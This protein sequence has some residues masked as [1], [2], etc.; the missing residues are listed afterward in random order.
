M[1]DYV[2]KPERTRRR[3]RAVSAGEVASQAPPFEPAGR[4]LSFRVLGPVEVVDVRGPVSVGGPKERLVLAHLLAR[5]NTT[6]SVDALVEGVWAGEPPRSAE[7]TLQAYVARLRKALEPPRPQGDAPSLLVTVGRGY[8]LDLGPDQLDAIQF[9][10]LARRGADELRAGD[11]AAAGTL[12]RALGLWRGEPYGEFGGYEACAPEARRLAEIR[13]VALEDRLDADLA[14]GDAAQV[15][16]EAEGLLVDYSF[17]ERLWGQLMLALYRSGRQRDALAAYQRARAVLV[18]ELGIEPGPDLRRLEAA[19]LAQDPSLDVTRPG[20]GTEPGGLPLVLEAVGSA[21]VGRDTE[22]AWLREGWEEAAAGRGRFVSVLGPEGIG[23]T[24]LIT[25]LARQAHSEGAVVL[26]GRCDHAHPGARALLDQALRSAGGS[27]ARLDD[28]GSPVDDLAGAVARFLPTWSRGRPVLLLLDDLHLA[29]TGT[30]E[31]LADLAGWCSAAPMLVVGAFRADGDRG[32]GTGQ[33]ALGGLDDDA[34]GRICALYAEEGWATGDLARLRE[35]TGGVPLRVHEQA[36]EWARQRAARRVEETTDR[37]TAAR[38]RVATSRGELAE[39]VE[40]I[41]RLLEERRAQLAGREV[42]AAADQAGSV[43]GRCPYKGLARFETAD[44]SD[45]FGRER[46]VAEL[47]ARLAGAGLLAVVGPS[48]SGKSS[49]VR[50][51]LLPALADGVLPGTDRWQT[52][53]LCPGAHPAR[54]L[55]RQLRG[56]ADS[57]AA[58]R[59]LVFV[60]Q[61]EETF[62][63][64]DDETER[65]DFV[66]RLVELAERPT[67]VVVLAVRADHLGLCATYPELADLLTGNDVLVGPMRD[68]ELRR[69]VELPARR[70]GLDVEAGL[71]EVIVADVAGRAGALPL[72]S[73]AL[74]ETWE[75]RRDRTLTLA[76][77]RAA[78]GVNGA[79]ARLAEDAYQSMPAGARAAGRRVLLRLCDAG[80]DGTID[81]RRRLPMDEAAPAHDADARAA[82]DTLVDRRLLTVDRDSVEVAHEALLREWPRLRTWLDEDVQGRRLH[83]RLGDAARAWRTADRDPSELYRGT[84]LDSAVDWAAAHGADLN[85]VEQEFLDASRADAEREVEEVKRRSAEKTR[86]NRRL[87]GL[88]AGVAVLLVIALASGLL[89]LR[90]RDRAEREERVTRVR[91][92]SGESALALEEDPE[93]SI[94]LGLEA[95]GISRAAG[96]EPLPEAIGALQR[97]VQESR[98]ELRVDG[99]GYNV[100][101]SADGGLL[102]AGA[103]DG[104]AAVVLDA[105]TGERLRELS[106]PAGLLLD[107]LAFAPDG[108]VVTSFSRGEDADPAEGGPV[109]IMWDPETGEASTRLPGRGT[110]YPDTAFTRDGRLLAASGTQQV[111]VWDVPSGRELYTIE[112][113]PTGDVEFLP[114]DDTFI[115]ALG[116]ERIGFY[117]AADGHAVGELATPGFVPQST[118]LDPSGELLALA[119]QTSRALQ[120]WNLR[121]RDRIWSMALG[122]TAPLD[123]SPDGRQLAIGGGNL[124]P[125]QVLDVESGAITTLRGHEQVWDVA[126]VSQDRLASVDPFDGLRIWN[127]TRAGPPELGAVAASTGDAFGVQVSPDG[128]EVAITTVGGRFERVDLSTGE[129]LASISGQLAS[130]GSTP[131]ISPD[132]R[133]MASVSATDGRP[134]VRDLGTLEPIHD[135]PPCTSPRAFSPDGSLIVLNGRQPCPDL[136][137]PPP[138]VEL[139]SRVVEVD[140]GR[141]VLAFG[142]EVEF[143]NAAAFSSSGQYLAINNSHGA[144]EVYDMA[145]EPIEQ[146]AVL[147]ADDLGSPVIFGPGDRS[148]TVL[149]GGTPDGQVWVYDMAEATE[150]SSAEP[151]LRFHRRVHTGAVVPAVSGRGLLATTVAAAPIRL[152]DLDS[153]RLIAELPTDFTGWPSMAFSPDGSYLL[154]GDTG[155]VLRRYYLDVERLID[156]AESRLTRGFTPDECRQYL[157]LS[158]CEELGLSE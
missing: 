65:E 63:H 67:A 101:A 44:A 143:L 153:G 97:A 59:L 94:L 45:F 37:L 24:R 139:T 113:G 122:D 2:E 70:V 121:T 10:T 23:K 105:A 1:A 124:G 98:L 156:L 39:S 140:S 17:R 126:F 125:V 137:P 41:G 7:R 12:R 158:R 21:F 6:V 147:R 80:D 16:A 28:G 64:C 14:A 54:E 109:V 127:I 36:S 72:L 133:Y 49:L 100:D 84:R 32:D 50:A 86:T 134:T 117:A 29:D 13:L 52:V 146:V 73:T 132:W 61:F 91:E 18:D 88:L 82:V 83:R 93:R 77:Y 56:S 142:A 47:V 152:W 155:G 71:V 60:D 25:Q 3:L 95:V 31:V 103:P 42:P 8:R 102:V 138:D 135:L 62:T 110:W 136:F 78:G 27:L 120:I 46:L 40:G 119:S 79:L 30:L 11:P 35:L 150:G 20:P 112:P 141:E 92:L 85:E 19:I 5:V 130:I 151:A 144:V 111:T 149:A 68:S 33:L 81:L 69:A 90:Q 99:V 104:T 116:D 66:G 15:A 76:A 107:S 51:G 26:Y 38:A 87:R 148:G 108:R 4:G 74:A 75:R 157:E 96:E 106:A 22:L 128:S 48:G 114:S 57:G 145:A 9:E 58:D 118:A 129:V 123:W 115:V 43:F 131:I 89:F 55:A 53:V 34:I 154:Y